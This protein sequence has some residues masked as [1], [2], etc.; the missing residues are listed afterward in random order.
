MRSKL[1]ECL[2]LKEIFEVKVLDG[3]V[4]LRVD[5]EFKVLVIF[6]YRGYLNLWRILYLEFLVG[7]RRGFVK[8]EEL[9]RFVLGDDLERRMVVVDE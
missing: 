3:I 8:F 5:G 7:E 9:R 6:G 4:L 2:F 1:F